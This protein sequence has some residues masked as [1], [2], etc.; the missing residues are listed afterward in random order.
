MKQIGIPIAIIVAGVLIAGAVLYSGDLG[1]SKSGAAAQSLDYDATEMESLIA[2][3]GVDGKIL[4]DPNA[5]IIITEYSDTECP[6]CQR[7]H[8]TMKQVIE[9]YG[10]DGQV[11]WEYK[12]FPIPQL[13]SK[14]PAESH[15]LECIFELGGGE[16]FWVAIDTIYTVSPSNNGLDLA[17]L[18][19]IAAVSGVD[20]D[21]F[22]DCQDSDRHTSRV[23]TDVAEAQA[24]GASGTPHSVLRLS[25]PIDS[26]TEQFIEDI[27]E[28]VSSG[29]LFQIVEN[30]TQ[31]RMSGAL[32][33]DMIDQIV[34]RILG[35]EA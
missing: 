6:F 17:L 4:G 7:Y 27:D 9:K 19:D 16:A 22:N 26:E 14:A 31:I 25:S 1:S 10:A 35:A 21:A 24:N 11:A 32:P 18:P 12:H 15:A 3:V 28:Q 20:V 2:E 33:F 13:H 23:E 29:D 34:S 30:G 5:P 8:G